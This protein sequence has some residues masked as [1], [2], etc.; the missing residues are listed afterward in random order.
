MW[1]AIIDDV[2]QT[3]IAVAAVTG[4][5][6]GFLNNRKIQRVHVD[7]N[8]RMDQLLHERGISAFHEGRMT[9]QDQ[10]GAKEA[11][12][13]AKEAAAD[14]KDAAKDTKDAAKDLK[15]AAKGL[16]EP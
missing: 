3:V 7:V 14:T 1:V 2:A 16:K 12:V 13:A 11:V 6:L 4:V 10:Q 5:I 15:D 9:G 8:S